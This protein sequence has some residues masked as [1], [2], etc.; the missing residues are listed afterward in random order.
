MEEFTRRSDKFTLKNRTFES[1]QNT[2]LISVCKCSFIFLKSCKER[3]IVD[4]YGRQRP[5][6][7]W[8]IK[9]DAQFID[10][11]PPW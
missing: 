5:E 8:H 10:S 2:E 4:S 7:T 11:Q 1:V 9:E 3:E 6:E